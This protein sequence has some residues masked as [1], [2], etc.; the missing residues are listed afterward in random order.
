MM[1]SDNRE[2]DSRGEGG[3]V[4]SGNSRFLNFPRRDEEEKEK[5]TKNAYHSHRRRLIGAESIRGLF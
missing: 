2:K 5:L 4:E 3:H 1:L